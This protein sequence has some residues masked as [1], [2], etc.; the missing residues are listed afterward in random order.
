MSNIDQVLKNLSY[1]EN[2]YL[3][4][5]KENMYRQGRGIVYR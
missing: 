2:M 1:R 4:D 5:L 3:K